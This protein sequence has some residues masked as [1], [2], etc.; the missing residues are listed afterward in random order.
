MKHP[1]LTAARAT[2]RIGGLFTFLSTIPLWAATGVWTST[3]SGNWS[4]T[5]RWSATPVADGAGFTADFNTINPTADVVVTLDTART[6]GSLVFGDTTTVDSAAGWTLA[7]TNTLTLATTPTITVNALG[8]GKSV[9]ISAPL[10]GTA[11]FTKQGVGRLLLTGTNNSLSGTIAIK[12]TGG[13][14]AITSAAALGSA[15]VNMPDTSNVAGGFE[16]IGSGGNITLSNSVRIAGSGP[17]GTG[18]LRN[19]SGNNTLSNFGF[20]HNKAGGRIDIEGGSSLRIQNSFV[21]DP[22]SFGIRLIGS[23]TLI[24]DA[25]NSSALHGWNVRF[26]DATNAGPVIEAG[27]DK[28]LG[29]GTVIF[30]ANSNP[31]LQSKDTSAR[32]FANPLTINATSA[33]LGASATGDLSFTGAVSLAANLQLSVHN[34]VA[35]SNSITQDA[36]GRSLTKKGPGTLALAGTNNYS[37][38]T[39]VTSGTLLVNNTSGSGLGTGTV[40]VDGGILGGTGGF[41]G[42]ATI[43]TTGVLSP[44]ASIGTFGTGALTLESGSTFHYELNTTATTG[45]LLNVNGDINLNATASL[46]LMD[47]GAAV[48]L[49]LGTKFTLMSYAGNWN[50]VG[51]DG[52]DDLSSFSRFNNRWMINYDDSPD[53]SVNGGAFASAVTLTVIPEPH[54]ALLGGLGILALLRRRR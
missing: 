12:A 40:S 45:D 14:V 25:D 9:E 28:S 30:E 31:T 7:G 43:N 20:S 22:G 23:G 17:S 49:A 44:G 35:L 50:G 27:N 18:A 8:T 38:G 15:S 16:L 6:L 47:L 54:A 46:A 41:S 51:F 42:A 19:I 53:G 11:G 36:S 5:S 29:T 37:G 39:T 26:G 52:Y 33:T 48:P 2:A 21:G 4:D 34:T 3:G 1:Y 10:A 24:L 13:T 32:T